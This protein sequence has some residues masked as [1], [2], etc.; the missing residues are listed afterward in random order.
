MSSS[1]L[2]EKINFKKAYRENRLG[3]A[4]WVLAN[5]ETFEELLVY[6][7]GKDKELAKKATWALEFIARDKLDMLYLHLDFFFDNLPHATGDG[8]LRSV[9]FICELLCIEHY[10]KKNEVLGN[11]LTRKHK[12]IMTDCAFDWMITNQKVACQARAMTALYFLGTEQN[13]IHPEL[14]QIIRQNMHQGSAGYKARGKN[15]LDLIKKF[16]S[17]L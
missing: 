4:N 7:F 1:E 8:A 16:Q 12:L 5:P 15:T 3:A 13:W 14:V 6:C 9:G 17:N 2:F 11:S 10:K